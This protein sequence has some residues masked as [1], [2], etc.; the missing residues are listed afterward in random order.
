MRR[1][2]RVFLA[3]LLVLL[4]VLLPPAL[5]LA[6]QGLR[7]PLAAL[8][9]PPVGVE[10]AAMVERESL[11]PEPS[12]ADAAASPPPVRRHR[13]LS[14][15]TPA[16]PDFGP[17][18]LR[19]DLPADWQE[20]ERLPVLVLVSG[21]R[22]GRDNIEQFPP[23]GRNAVVGYSYPFPHRLSLE[24]SL[25]LEATPRLYDQVMQSPGQVAVMLAWIRQ[26]SW[27]DP[28]RITLLAASLGSIVSPA[29]WRLAEERGARPGA[30]VIGYGGADLPLLMRTGFRKGIKSAALRIPMAE[31]LGLLLAPL[32]PKTH[33]PRMGGGPFLILAGDTDG[34]IPEASIDLLRDLTPEPKRFQR[35]PG[36]HVGDE[37]EA[38]R[39]ALAAT[40]EWLLDQGLINPW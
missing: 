10:I 27:A 22:K 13:W 14:L 23:L 20:G 5:F 17:L 21:L 11:W 39:R 30:C 12:A 2:R 24:D 38:T 32:E 28:E 29:A 8:P 15:S 25:G 7:D 31:A 34:M 35:L 37:A 36:G 6:W 33:L 26:Q 3:L 18:R 16:A 1:L 4:L 9:R 40:K 19:L